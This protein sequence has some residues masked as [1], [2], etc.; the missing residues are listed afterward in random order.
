[1]FRMCAGAGRRRKARCEG[2]EVEGRGMVRRYVAAFARTFWRTHLASRNPTQ[3][4]YN[5]LLCTRPSI[6]TITLL[7]TSDDVDTRPSDTV[8]SAYPH[9]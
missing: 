4:L 3:Q 2:W 1:M 8:S 6:A 5:I 7:S 9:S